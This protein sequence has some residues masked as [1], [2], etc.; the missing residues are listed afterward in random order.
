MKHIK[1]IATKGL[2]GRI[3]ELVFKQHHGRTLVAAS[4]SP[5]SVPASEQQL[6][7]RFTFRDAVRYAKAILTNIDIKRAYKAKADHWQSAY[8]MAVA[9]FFKPPTIGTID[10]S[11][12]TTQAGSFITAQVTDD[13]RAASVEVRIENASGQLVEAGTAMLMEDGLHYRYTTTTAVANITGNKITFIATDLP[14]H[15][16]TK[17]T[18][19]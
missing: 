2:S 15:L 16:V 1:N 8:N 7:I 18:I 10:A 12:Y 4:P 6:L 17:Q 5:S 13:F 3:Q 11:H 19:L 14:G 9:D